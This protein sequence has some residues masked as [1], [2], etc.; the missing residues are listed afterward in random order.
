[1][2]E[3]RPASLVR[4][5]NRQEISRWLEEDLGSEVVFRFDAGHADDLS[6][7]PVRFHVLS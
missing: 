2:E 1:M 6:L 7:L 3:L 4:A 5:H